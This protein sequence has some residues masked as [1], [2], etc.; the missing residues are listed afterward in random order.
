MGAGAKRQGRAAELRLQLQR[1]LF[2]P[3]VPKTHQPVDETHKVPPHP[4]PP[5]SVGPNLSHHKARVRAV[6]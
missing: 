3:C 2:R 6:G 1:Q 5:P 4:V